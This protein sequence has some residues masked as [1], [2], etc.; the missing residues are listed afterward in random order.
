MWRKMIQVE[1]MAGKLEMNLPADE[2]E[3][4]AEFQHQQETLDMIREGLLDFPLAAWIGCTEKVE[5]VGVLKTWTAMSDS[6]GGR[7]ALKFVTA[8]PWRLWSPVSIWKQRTGC[9]QPCSIVFRA[10]HC[11]IG[12]HEGPQALGLDQSFDFAEEIGITAGQVQAGRRR[13][14]R[15]IKTREKRG[16]KPL[17]R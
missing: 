8:L 11:R 1:I 17:L 15:Q 7:V 2:S 14:K 10:Y 16:R 6:A 5:Q 3:A 9:D 12:G 13:G 4:G